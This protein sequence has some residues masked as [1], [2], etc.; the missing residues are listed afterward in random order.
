MAAT[1]S[2]R[3]HLIDSLGTKRHPNPG[4]PDDRGP[5]LRRHRDGKRSGPLPERTG[6]G[7]ARVRCPQCT[8][9]HLLAFS[10]QTRIFC[11]SCQAK[12]AALLGENVVGKVVARVSHRHVVFTVPKA[13]RG[14]LEGERRLLGL[15]SRSA[16]ESVRR[17]WATG[18]GERGAPPTRQGSVRA[19][20]SWRRRWHTGTWCSRCRRH[21]GDS[22]SSGR[23]RVERDGG[24]ARSGDS[25]VMTPSLVCAG[26]R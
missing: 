8:G 26:E 15:L 9:E 18:F 16:Y 25:S 13:L 23:A 6:N 21:G 12:R 2:A 10:C 5:E 14:S 19:A 7:F 4:F 3:R 17:T 1:S 11:P 24:A 22:T 20:T